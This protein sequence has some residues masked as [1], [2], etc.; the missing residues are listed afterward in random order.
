M[1]RGSWLSFRKPHAEWKDVETQKEN[2]IV[3]NSICMKFW[4]SK[5]LGT[6]N[7]YIGNWA[8]SVRSGLSANEYNE[9]NWSLEI[10]YIL[11]LVGDYTYIHL[12]KLLLIKI[13]LYVND[14][15]YIILKF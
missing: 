13:L 14:I 15:I 6:E 9:T 8:G 10:V 2:W 3:C 11:I 4:N 12:S 5:N 1:H 7:N